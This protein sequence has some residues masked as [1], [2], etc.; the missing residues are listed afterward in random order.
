MA[1]QHD[2][3]RTRSNTRSNDLQNI[4]R[5]SFSTLRRVHLSLVIDARDVV[6]KGFFV[7]QSIFFSRI[8]CFEINSRAFETKNV[9]TMQRAHDF[10]RTDS[11]FRMLYQ[12]VVDSFL[13]E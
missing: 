3:R 11:V 12:N 5:N 1:L 10:R 8:S 7:A 6:R 4:Q 9:A 13:E 2:L